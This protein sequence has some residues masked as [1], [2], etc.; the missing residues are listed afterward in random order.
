MIWSVMESYDYLNDIP[1]YPENIEQMIG[2]DHPNLHIYTERRSRNHN[3][4]VALHATLG[5][6]LFGGE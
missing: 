3:E 6:M 2:A 5:W 1:F 4:P